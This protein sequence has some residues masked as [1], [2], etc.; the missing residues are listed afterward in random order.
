VQSTER[1]GTSNS[2]TSRDG[3]HQLRKEEAELKSE[4]LL[5]LSEKFRLDGAA[6]VP[7]NLSVQT[8]RGLYV[9]G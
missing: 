2:Q 8:A 9:D 4:P 5:F 6:E 1:E 7:L 3:L